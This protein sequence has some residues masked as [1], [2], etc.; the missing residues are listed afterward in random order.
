VIRRRD[1]GIA[2]CKER[3]HAAALIAEWRSSVRRQAHAVVE[4]LKGPD[5][6][7]KRGEPY[8]YLEVVPDLNQHL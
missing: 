3:P 2:R 5:A 4:T 6:N 7:E 1:F 8:L